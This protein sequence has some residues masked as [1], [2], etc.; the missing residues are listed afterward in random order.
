M[1]A[2]SFGESKITRPG[3]HRVPLFAVALPIGPGDVS[4][5]AEGGL[6]AFRSALSPAGSPVVP[7]PHIPI[8][9]WRLSKVGRLAQRRR[10]SLLM[11]GW[12]TD[13]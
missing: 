6:P 3:P 13:A 1:F 10:V 11:R 2:G 7:I 12:P 9:Q 5:G 8:D 4:G